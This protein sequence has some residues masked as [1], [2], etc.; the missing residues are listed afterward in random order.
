MIN[1]SIYFI[2]SFHFIFIET[3]KIDNIISIY[4]MFELYHDL[5]NYKYIIINKIFFSIYY[6]IFVKN[7]KISLKKVL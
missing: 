6:L 2:I 7:Y 3:D 4:K 5:N 1:V